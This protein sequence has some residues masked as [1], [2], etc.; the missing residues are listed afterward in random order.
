VGLASEA[1]IPIVESHDSGAEAVEFMK[2]A[3]NLMA[4]A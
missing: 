2:V 3:K 1:G 4:Q